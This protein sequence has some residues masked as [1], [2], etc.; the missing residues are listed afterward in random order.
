MLMIAAQLPPID[1]S[2]NKKEKRWGKNWIRHFRKGP[3]KRKTVKRKAKLIV[4]PLEK[5]DIP[6]G[7]CYL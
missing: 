5:C 2:A 1:T 6:R 3:Q 4:F 7:H